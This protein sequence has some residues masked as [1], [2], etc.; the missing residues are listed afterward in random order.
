MPAKKEKMK[1][2][3]RYFDMVFF[4]GK[5]HVETMNFLYLILGILD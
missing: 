5:G 4:V 3:Q 1:A 2:M